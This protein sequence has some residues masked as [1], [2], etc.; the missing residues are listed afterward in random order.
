MRTGPSSQRRGFIRVS[1][2]LLG[3]VVLTAIGIAAL[4]QDRRFKNL[5]FKAE[6][7]QQRLEL[8][9]AAIARAASLGYDE[10]Y[11]DYL[12]LQSIQAFGSGWITPNQDTKPIV[13]YFDNLTDI[14]PEYIAAYRFGNL[15]VGDQR[16]D[17]EGGRYL[18]RKGTIANYR[19]DYSLPYL[20]LYNSIWEGNNPADGRWFASYLKKAPETPNFMLRLEEYI[21]RKAG[22]FDAAYDINMRYLLEYVVTNNDLERDIMMRRI[23]DVLGRQYKAALTEGAKRFLAEHHRHP[24]A[25]EELL[26]PE[27]LPAYN[28]GSMGQ[29]MA[30]LEKHDE[31]LSQKQTRQ[32]LDDA[33]VEQVIADSRQ[34][35]IGL[36]P[37]PTG[38]WYFI[39][40]AWREEMIGNPSLAREGEPLPYI[41]TA[42]EMLEISDGAS[43]SA[44]GYIM[45]FYADN[46][47]LPTDHDMRYYLIRDGMGGRYVYQRV[48]PESPTY[49][50]FFSTSA[51][52]VIDKIEPRM[53]VSG[54]G[55]FPFQ[56]EPRLRDHA[57]DYNWA[58]KQGFIEPGTGK[59][60]YRPF[61]LE[62]LARPIFPIAFSFGK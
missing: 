45:Q 22:R 52:R 11:A 58:L 56:L 29:L 53:G 39:N 8:A 40:S 5:E 10:I 57:D 26:R 46:K 28:A 59:E 15:V 35:I 50:V 37:E 3:L 61:L 41:V 34:P 12:W 17:Y 47:T 48:A 33:F 7:F 23:S 18:L 36:P 44:Q 2:L 32:D 20:G 4:I 60:L 19:R 6:L 51:R 25:M 24:R 38:S 54:P 31:A 43:M 55:P 49:G 21:E 30:A 9:P 14:A 27:Y 62:W 1:E 13:K 42:R 16:R